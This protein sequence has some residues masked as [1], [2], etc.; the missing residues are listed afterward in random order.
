VKN[1]GRYCILHL[2]HSNAHRYT[3]VRHSSRDFQNPGY[4]EVFK[5]AIHGTGYPLPGGY[6]ELPVCFAYND[7]RSRVGMPSATLQRHATRERYRMNSHTGE[8][9]KELTIRSEKTCFFTPA[10]T[11]NN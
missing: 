3:Q 10:F 1:R 4:M 11:K 6:G 9:V 2:Y 8:T 5:L 7:E